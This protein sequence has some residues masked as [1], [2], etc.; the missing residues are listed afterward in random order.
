M[1]AVVASPQ[2]RWLLFNSGQP[3]VASRP[4][5]NKRELAYLS[6]K[7]VR[8]L[9]GPT[10]FFGQGRTPGNLLEASEE[11]HFTE[12][13]RHLTSPVVFL[14]LKELASS[15]NALPSSD[16]ANADAAVENLEGTPYFSIDVAELSFDDEQLDV[17]LKDT[18]LAKDGQVLSWSEPRVILSALDTLHGGICAEARS[19]VD[20]NQR[21]KAHTSVC[22]LFVRSNRCKSSVQVVARP[23]IPC[24]VA[25]SFLALHYFPGQITLAENRVLQC[26]SA[27]VVI[28]PAHTKVHA[29]SPEKDCTTS[30]ILEQMLSSS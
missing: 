11:N 23:I 24:G 28:I 3:L 13:A 10:P 30:L 6:T 15:T 27:P 16:F 12:A 26:V 25:G 17:I 7:D 14:G 21:N 5:A 2:T 19:M 9:L 29:S 18:D 1:N 20:W 8:P 4:N 22:C